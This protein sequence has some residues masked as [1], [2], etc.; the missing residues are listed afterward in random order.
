MA[1]DKLGDDVLL[2]L[3]LWMLFEIDAQPRI[4]K[5]FIVCTLALTRACAGGLG[6]DEDHL[7]FAP[8]EVV[9]DHNLMPIPCKGLSGLRNQQRFVSLELYAKSVSDQ[10][11]KHIMIYDAP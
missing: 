7:E 10:A 1:L 4:F 3:L 8:V 5:P 6:G 9:P 11:S 2:D